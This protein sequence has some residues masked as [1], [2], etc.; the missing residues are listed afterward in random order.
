MKKYS[1]L[2]LIIPLLFNIFVLHTFYEKAAVSIPEKPIIAVKKND[3]KHFRNISVKN[4]NVKIIKY[5]PASM[6]IIIDDI[7]DN[8]NRAIDFWNISDNITLSI[9]PF[10][11]YSVMISNYGKDYKLPVMMHLPMEPFQKLKNYKHFLTTFQNKRD[12][13]KTLKENLNSLPYYQGINN[14][15]GSK[16]TSDFVRLSWFFDFLKVTGIFFID[17]R[18]YKTSQAASISLQYKVLTGV[19]DF[20][21]DNRRDENYIENQ[22]LKA[23]KKAI[24]TGYVI[25][26][27]HPHVETVSALKKF[28][29]IKKV[30]IIP[31]RNGLQ[32]FKTLEKK[33]IEK[34]IFSQNKINN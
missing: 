22:L 33:R 24:E 11:K 10:R 12:F 30:N 19:R 26:I 3:K 5:I 25:A 32:I 9:F 6:T 34:K 27:G 2:F 1:S 31:A 18:T 23:Q 29:K 15:M 14:H 17:S 7:G 21:I 8:F 28:F 16:L 13:Y 4:K 20:F